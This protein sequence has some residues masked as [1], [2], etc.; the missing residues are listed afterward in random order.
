MFELLKHGAGNRTRRPRRTATHA[1]A[2]VIVRG[3]IGW[4]ERIGDNPAD[5]CVR[6]RIVPIFYGVALRSRT[7]RA[8]AGWSTLQKVIVGFRESM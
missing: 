7:H 3:G 2:R 6:Y 5:A 8:G 1:V 4:Q